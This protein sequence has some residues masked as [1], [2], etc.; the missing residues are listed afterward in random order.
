MFFSEL[1]YRFVTYCV[2]DERLAQ[3]M[4]FAWHKNNNHYSYMIPYLVLDSRFREFW[5]ISVHQLTR[6]GDRK[7][8]ELNECECQCVL[9]EHY[10][11]FTPNTLSVSG[12][13][14]FCIVLLMVFFIIMV[15]MFF[16]CIGV[17]CSA[18]IYFIDMPVQYMLLLVNLIELFIEIQIVRGYYI[19]IMNLLKRTRRQVPQLKY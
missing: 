10:V 18:F 3:K 17:Y 16:F 2:N 14:C 12:Q 13:L 7:R 15:K 4:M 11:D 5:R 1:L 8:P 9:W 6:G 19:I